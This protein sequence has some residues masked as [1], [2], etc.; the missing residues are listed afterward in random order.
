MLQKEVVY[1][2][3]N[4]A[5]IGELSRFEDNYEFIYDNAYVRNIKTFDLSLSLPKTG[6][7]Y[8]S[9]R[10]FSFFEGLLTEGWLRKVQEDTQHIDES[11]SFT[12][13]IK[14]GESLI[15]A[16]KILREKM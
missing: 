16:I 3:M 15:G 2:Y 9:K 14:N 7:A 4:N 8:K 12:R 5:F 10:L 1:I 11:D 13:L 6:K